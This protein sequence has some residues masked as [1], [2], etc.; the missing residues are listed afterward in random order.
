MLDF[1]KFSWMSQPL[2]L[3]EMNPK[4]GKIGEVKITESEIREIIKGMWEGADMESFRS[5]LY[6]VY[7]VELLLKRKRREI[8]LDGRNGKNVS[9]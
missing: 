1:P 7:K 3:Q 4:Q 5:F 8:W 9:L 6:P 2:D